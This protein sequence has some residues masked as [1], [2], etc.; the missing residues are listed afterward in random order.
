MCVVMLADEVRPSEEMIQ[1]AFDTNGDGCGI[2]WR[3]G[4]D[5]FW[6]KGITEVSEIKA[7][8]ASKPLP[9]LIHFR[10][11]TVGGVV[12]RLTHPFPISP[13]APLD[14]EGK[15]AGYVL[16]HNG[17][18][19]RWRDTILEATIK[20]GVKLPVGK[21]SDSR[22]LAWF[23]GAFG[24]G[25]LELIDEKVI[26]FGPRSYHIFGTNWSYVDKVLCSN[27]LFESRIS[28][29]RRASAG[30]ENR[31]QSGEN[32]VTRP[33]TEGTSGKGNYYTGYRGPTYGKNPPLQVAT[34]ANPGP[35]RPKSVQ[36][37]T[38]PAD[39]FA[40]L[41]HLYM[42]A[43]ISKKAWK[44]GKKLIRRREK[45]KLA[46]AAEKRLSEMEGPSVTLH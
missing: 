5:V 14:L 7:L 10:I 15:I 45:E 12:K 4:N 27:R 11:Q 25:M 18:W 28:S 31:N 13:D 22:A 21:W 20:S 9:Q 23:S 24:L 39:P 30:H 44:R 35:G 1:A 41:N 17:H 33:G 19:G 2:A 6:K 16:A 42:E 32:P 3:E 37:V 34:R 38:D 43:K 29:N 26:A 8:I 46:A 40:Q 36:G